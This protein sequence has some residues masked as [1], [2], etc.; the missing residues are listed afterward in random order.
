MNDVYEQYDAAMDMHT[1]DMLDSA[2]S[3]LSIA[4]ES[5]ECGHL[6]ASN[7][8]GVNVCVYRAGHESLI[9]RLEDENTKL[10][11]SNLRLR[12]DSNTWKF[13]SF[14]YVVAFVIQLFQ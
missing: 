9:T 3:L 8:F 2:S 11:L 12:R 14:I 4:E 13:I 7:S 5:G 10:K 1:M 6:E